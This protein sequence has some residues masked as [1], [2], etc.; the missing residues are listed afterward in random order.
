MTLSEKR[1]ILVL[2]QKLRWYGI[3]GHELEW[4]KNH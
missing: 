2:L 3:G 1:N 4:F